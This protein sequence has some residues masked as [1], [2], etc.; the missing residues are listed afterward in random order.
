MTKKMTH[1]PPYPQPRGLFNNGEKF[2][3]QVFVQEFTKVA[4]R[5]LLLGNLD[6][7]SELPTFSLE[8]VAF[9]TARVVR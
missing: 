1:I 3:P 5:V 9:M 8:E 6:P 4:E 2:S 7:Q